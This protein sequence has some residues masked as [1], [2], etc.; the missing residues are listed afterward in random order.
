[1]YIQKCPLLTRHPPPGRASWCT[2]AYWEERRRVG[3]LFPVHSPGVEVFSL[4]PRPPPLGDALSLAAL[5]QDNSCPSDSTLRTREKI[6]LGE[7]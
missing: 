3:Q 1:M 5:A 4:A 2:L 6:G 7:H